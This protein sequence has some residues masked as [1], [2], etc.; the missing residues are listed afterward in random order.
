MCCFHLT[1][2]QHT[3]FALY[4]NSNFITNNTICLAEHEF[5][6]HLKR[7]IIIIFNPNYLQYNQI[8]DTYHLIL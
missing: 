1:N 4:E 2:V 7:I 8:R 6:H 5:Q 3:K